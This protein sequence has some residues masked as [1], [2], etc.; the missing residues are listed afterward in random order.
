MRLCQRDT[1]K[2]DDFLDLMTEDPIRAPSQDLHQREQKPSIE[3]LLF[4][5]IF[6]VKKSEEI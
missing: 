2:L 4:D 6:Q 5:M 3:I 1:K